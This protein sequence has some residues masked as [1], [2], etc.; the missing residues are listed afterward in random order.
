MD[1]QLIF[2]EIKERFGSSVKERD[3]DTYLLKYR[4]SYLKKNPNDPCPKGFIP[5]L[6]WSQKRKAEFRNLLHMNK[7]QTVKPP[8]PDEVNPF[9]LKERGMNRLKE[10][11][12]KLR[13][14]E[15]N[16]RT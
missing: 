14:N 2:E 9:G 10:L 11:E 7:I 12:R 1:Y 8:Y 16:P 3:L 6:G 13:K 15:A 5:A 4:Q